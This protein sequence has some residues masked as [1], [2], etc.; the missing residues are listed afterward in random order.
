[1][2]QCLEWEP[3]GSSYQPPTKEPCENGAVSDQSV[4]SGLID[5]NLAADM[6]DPDLPPNPRKAVIYHPSISHLIAVRVNC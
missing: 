5:I 6:M 1:M 2:L 3:S 4:T